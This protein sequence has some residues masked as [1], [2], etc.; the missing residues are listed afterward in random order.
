MHVLN[1]T[2]TSALEGMQTMAEAKGRKRMTIV[3]TEGRYTTVDVTP[4]TRCTGITDSCLSTK[5]VIFG[6]D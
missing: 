6:S 4:N 5:R 3:E 2:F 1:K